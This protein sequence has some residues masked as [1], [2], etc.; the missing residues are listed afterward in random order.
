[1]G[2]SKY[3]NNHISVV[4]DGVAGFVKEAL[5]PRVAALL[6]GYGE[7]RNVK[8]TVFTNTNPQDPAGKATFS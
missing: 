8:G 1:M 2:D 3:N 6:W 7:D 5:F 4:D